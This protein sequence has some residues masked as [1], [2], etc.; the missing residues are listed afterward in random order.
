MEN[1]LQKVV[2][3]PVNVQ[4]YD[5]LSVAYANVVFSVS[6]ILRWQSGLPNSQNHS[7]HNFWPVYLRG[8]KFSMQ[9]PW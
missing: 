7:R 1:L 8:T 6:P 3:L 9:L 2:D 4:H 5:L